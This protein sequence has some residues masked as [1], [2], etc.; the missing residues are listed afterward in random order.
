MTV[1]LETLLLA[2]L[3]ASTVGFVAFIGF[4][5]WLVRRVYTTVERMEAEREDTWKWLDR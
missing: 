5:I 2:F 1:S 4:L 3:I